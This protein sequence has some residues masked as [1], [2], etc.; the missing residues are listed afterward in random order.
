MN[1]WR[2]RVSSSS[3]NGMKADPP[4]KYPTPEWGNEKPLLQKIAVDPETY[5]L[6][7]N[8]TAGHVKIWPFLGKYRV[9]SRGIRHYPVKPITYPEPAEA[10]PCHSG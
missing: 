8:V 5:I 4:H 3:I 9:R 7:P 2:V 1:D 10:S 6:T